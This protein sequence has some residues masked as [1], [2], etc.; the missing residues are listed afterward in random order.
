M[1]ERPLM[2]SALLG[3]AVLELAGPDA[4]AAAKAAPLLVESLSLRQAM[5]EPLPLTSSLIGAAMLAL[6][7]GD[8]A[9]AARL[10][11]AVD[12]ALAAIDAPV[13]AEMQAF[14]RRTR[15]KALDA[16]G[17]A[18]FESAWRSGTQWSLEHAVS[19]AL[20]AASAGVA[21]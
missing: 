19:T 20:Q 17:E 10:L 16:L 21:G 3:L 18:A 5:G 14:H 7:R 11:G 15:A 6:W 2:A 1:E 8:P 13:E 4:G 9:G 12:S